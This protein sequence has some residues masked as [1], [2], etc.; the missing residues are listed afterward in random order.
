MRR[1]LAL[2][3]GFALV[4][5]SCDTAD[6]FIDYFKEAHHVD[7]SDPADVLTKKEAG[8]ENEKAAL[9]TYT[10][11]RQ[12][13]HWTA[14]D[15]A[16]K[17]RQWDAARGQYEKAIEWSKVD[18]E[19]D[20]GKAAQAQEIA[21]LKGRVADAWLREADEN[22]RAQGGRVAQNDEAKKGF[23]KAVA[24]YKNAVTQAEDA[25]R[26]ARAAGADFRQHDLQRAK[27]LGRASRAYYGAANDAQACSTAAEALRID[28]D[29]AQ[30]K[31][32]HSALKC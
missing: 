25:A 30:A 19:S 8:N 10:G 21:H 3:L 32:V 18:A 4:L 6:L 5:S 24:T 13:Q 2:L 26:Y 23:L 31:A 7:L 14:G 12:T 20:A 27:F 29:Q 16:Y 9:G 22:A 1:S 11:L 17:V 15:L 28:P